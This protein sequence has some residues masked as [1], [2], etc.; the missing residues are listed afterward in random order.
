MLM[1]IYAAIAGGFLD[2]TDSDLRRLLGR[3][4]QPALDVITSAFT[5]H[6]EKR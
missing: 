1:S 6:A 5:A 4:P 3:P 2:S